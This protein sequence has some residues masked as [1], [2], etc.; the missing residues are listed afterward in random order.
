MIFLLF[1]FLFASEYYTSTQYMPTPEQ[2]KNYGHLSVRSLEEHIDVLE[3]IKAHH[4]S[5]GEQVP[6]AL[7]AELKSAKDFHPVSIM[8]A[9][10]LK[11]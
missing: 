4:I 9:R 3:G 2:Y 1:A 8:I 5:Q 7:K 11:K 6:V 10:E